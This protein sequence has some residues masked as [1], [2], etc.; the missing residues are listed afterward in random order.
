MAS[1]SFFTKSS[2]D[3]CKAVEEDG[4]DDASPPRETADD[5]DKEFELFC[6]FPMIEKAEAAP[7]SMVA[8]TIT[9]GRETLIFVFVF[10]VERVT[11]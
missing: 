4:T 5:R 3:I 11:C 10:V 8:P 6:D 9:Y 2:E 7:T 1:I